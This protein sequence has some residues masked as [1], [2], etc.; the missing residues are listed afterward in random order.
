MEHEVNKFHL[1]ITRAILF[2]VGALMGGLGVWQY[3]ETVQTSVSEQ[4]QIIIISVSALV[5]AFVLL[6]SGRPIYYVCSAIKSVIKGFFSSHDIGGVVT[7]LCGMLVGFALVVPIEFLLQLCLP[8][9]AVRLLVD[10]VSGILLA[11]V[12][13]YGALFFYNNASRS[14]ASDKAIIHKSSVGYLLATDAFFTDNVFY[15]PEVLLNVG[16]SS[17]TAN[18]LISRVDEEGGVAALRRYK[19]LLPRLTVIEDKKEGAVSL[20]ARNKLKLVTRDGAEGSVSLAVF[21]PYE[22]K[23]NTYAAVKDVTPPVAPVEERKIEE[24]KP[25]LTGAEVLDMDEVPGEVN[26]EV[27]TK[28][29]T[30]RINKRK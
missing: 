22:V 9:L 11:A 21:V 27:F 4:F 18:E 1:A 13:S 23:E 2:T 6:F 26:V 24:E 30:G 10:I 19:A 29:R 5:A 14:A 16:V 12:F 7:A 3:F 8:V 17:A 20:A 15:A 25:P 28:H